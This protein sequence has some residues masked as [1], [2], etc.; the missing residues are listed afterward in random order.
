M[1][2]DELATWL[3]KVNLKEMAAP[4]CAL[5]VATMKELK[6]SLRLNYVTVDA[7]KQEGAKR[8]PACKFMDHAKKLL[9]VSEEAMKQERGH[10][11][12]INYLLFLLLKWDQAA[13]DK[14]WA[15]WAT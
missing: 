14:R 7:L 13:F 15:E 3:G 11:L 6:N 5:G 8:I 4:L 1:V 12:V 9:Q 2:D 10:L